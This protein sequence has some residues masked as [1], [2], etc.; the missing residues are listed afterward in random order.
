MRLQSIVARKIFKRWKAEFG[1]IGP[2][3]HEQYNAQVMAEKKSDELLIYNVKEGWEPLCKFLNVPIPQ[4]K[5]FPHVNDTK[6][7]QHV[8][9]MARVMGWSIWACFVAVLSVLIYFFLSMISFS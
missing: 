6:H 4:D 1:T 7:I 8:I 2:H 5:P 3:I 9:R